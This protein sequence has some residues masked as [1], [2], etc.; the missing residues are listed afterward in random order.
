MKRLSYRISTSNMCLNSKPLKTAFKILLL[1]PFKF[2]QL[3]FLSR[4]YFHFL[5][6]K[7]NNSNFENQKEIFARNK[8]INLTKTLDFS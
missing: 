7:S 8:A 4:I 3:K 1:F 5:L 6:E 2:Q